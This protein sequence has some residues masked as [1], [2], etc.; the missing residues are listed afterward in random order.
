MLMLVNGTEQQAI[1]ATD[2]GLQY[3]DGLFE[4]V[5]VRNGQ[6]CFWD[7]HWARLQ[8]G[9]CRL[10]IPA[11]DPGTL[12][13]EIERVCVGAERA[14]LKILVTRGRGGRGYRPPAQV[15][16]SR[17]V[18]LYPWPDYPQGFGDDG[19]AARICSTPCSI[20]PSLAGIKHLNRLDQVLARAEWDDPTI[21][22]GLMH[23]GRGVVV[24]GT[25]TNL[26]AVFAG[27]LMTPPLTDC[28]VAG[29]TR[30]RAL[31]AAAALGL[32]YRVAPVPLDRLAEAEE[33]FV[34]N[35]IVGIWPIRRLEKWAY[36][37]GPC[38]RRIAG[39]LAA[40]GIPV[41]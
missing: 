11:P 41:S 9:C 31:E 35:S 20:N 27:T 10:D 33:L 18:A 12:D 15:Q 13:Q 38:T 23:D 30:Q 21:A 32:P 39:A 16:P 25:M 28:G 1:T 17:I 14:V 3:G 7:R 8:A 4:T 29:I 34:C 37:V 2:R 19:I 40:D 26:F 36:G 22:E 6:P 5:A 24:S